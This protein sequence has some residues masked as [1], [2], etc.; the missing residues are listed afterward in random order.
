MLCLFTT[1][2]AGDLDKYVESCLRQLHI[3]G[4]SV[5]V[6]RNG[7]VIEAHGYGQANLEWRVP[8]ERETVYEIG[9]MTKQFTA[10]AIMML[11]EEGKVGLDDS[12]RKYF[13]AAPETW[14]SIT[15]RH[16]LNHTSGIQNHV[17]VP[18]Y[19][20]AFRTNLLMETTP[21]RDELLKMFFKLPLEF[22]PGETWA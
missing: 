18:G 5:A 13:A 11:V 3:P 15:V 2:R 4:A 21:S 22:Q 9:S 8:A 17:A 19:L 6:V 20:S 16:L 10:T 14:N 12:V 7:Q 1:A